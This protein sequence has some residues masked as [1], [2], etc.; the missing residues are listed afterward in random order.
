[1]QIAGLL[2]PAGLNCQLVHIIERVENNS[3]NAKSDLWKVK[4]YRDGEFI[5]VAA[6][7]LVH[8]GP[9]A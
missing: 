8:I 1:M 3:N 4:L 7:K 6:D 2:T 5:S 9:A